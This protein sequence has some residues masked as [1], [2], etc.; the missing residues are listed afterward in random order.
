LAESLWSFVL[1]DLWP[2]I[3]AEITEQMK[4]VTS[5]VTTSTNKMTQ[6]K[7]EKRLK[8]LKS[9]Y[10]KEQKDI[11][12]EAANAIR[13]SWAE[14]D[15]LVKGMEKSFRIRVSVVKVPE[16]DETHNRYLKSVMGELTGLRDDA[17]HRYD[18]KVSVEGIEIRSHD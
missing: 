4:T 5:K 8:E 1:S 9:K 14:Y 12:L 6:E 7:Y 2:I 3:E 13:A 10:E 15:R 16:S 11:R 18:A 17:P